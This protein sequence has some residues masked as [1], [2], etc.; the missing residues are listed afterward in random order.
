MNNTNEPLEDFSQP[1]WERIRRE[2]KA[3]EAFQSSPIHLRAKSRLRQ[4]LSQPL[5]DESQSMNHVEKIP[6]G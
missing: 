2:Y 6:E 3:L 1:V 5:P 4:I